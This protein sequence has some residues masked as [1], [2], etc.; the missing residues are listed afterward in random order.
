M[1]KGLVYKRKHKVWLIERFEV[2]KSPNCIN[3]MIKKRL[4]REKFLTQGDEVE[5]KE[6]IMMGMKKV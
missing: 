5:Y 2:G 6:F 3:S 4:K 1:D